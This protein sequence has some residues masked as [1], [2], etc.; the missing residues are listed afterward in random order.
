MRFIPLPDQPS[1]GSWAARYIVNR[2]NAFNPT[3][4]RPFTLGLPTGSTPIP[5]YLEL[6]RLY[7]SGVVSFSNVV[8]FNMD[9]YIGLPAQHPNSYRSFMHKHFFDHIDISPANINLL[10]GNAADPQAECQR[11][12]DKIDS[13]GGIELFMGGVGHDGHIA[14]NE[15]GSSLSSRTRVKTLTT[16]TRQANA[17]FFNLDINQ[18][19]KLALTVGVGTVLD[20]REVMI[21]ATGADKSRAVQATVEGSVNHMWTISAIQLHPKAMMVCDEPA[22]LDLKLRTLLYFRDIEE[23]NLRELY[24]G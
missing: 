16:Q 22:T 24:H 21:L 11:Y 23:Y 18:V 13:C 3:V 12:E 8:T 10:D 17:R 2:I 1:V 9:E 5:T 7:K 15:P 20:A 19:P 6:I 4:E 14:F